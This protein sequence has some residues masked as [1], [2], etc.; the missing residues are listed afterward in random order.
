VDL[1]GGGGTTRFYYAGGNGPHS[2]GGVELG[3]GRIV[4]SATGTPNLLVNL[5]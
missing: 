5:G 3:L 2:G 1:G 4:I